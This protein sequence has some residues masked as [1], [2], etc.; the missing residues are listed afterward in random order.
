[1]RMRR[2]QMMPLP[3]MLNMW[4]YAKFFESFRCFCPRC[5]DE[6]DAMA[7]AS[8]EDILEYLSDSVFGKELADFIEEEVRNRG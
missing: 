4:L 5:S 7:D 6:S 3:S 2:A 8:F 1:M